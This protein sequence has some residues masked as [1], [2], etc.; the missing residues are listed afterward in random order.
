[1]IPNYQLYWRANTGAYAPEVVLE[2]CQLKWHRI[3]V[4]PLERSEL[5]EKFR[6]LSPRG[7]VPVLVL[8]DGT[9]ITESVAMIL[10][11]ADAHPECQLLPAANNSQRAI[12]YRWLLFLATNVYDACL[13]IAYSHRYVSN[14]DS[15]SAVAEQAAL[16]LDRYW[17]IVEREIGAS[18]PPTASGLTLLD[19]YIHMLVS[20]HPRPNEL[21][22]R[23]P[24]IA[25]ISATAHAD[26]TIAR[27][28]QS[29]SLIMAT[30][31]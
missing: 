8:P 30:T 16:D 4:E 3:S 12:I 14:P 31:D 13:R 21:I 24:G 25:R 29:H 15:A 18:P 6:R 7:Q 26:P 23:C 5:D 28:D 1:M 10:H 2:L 17:D 27:V 11:L 22:A 19:I 20:W 9:S